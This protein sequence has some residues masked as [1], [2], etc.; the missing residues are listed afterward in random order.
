MKKASRNIFFFLILFIFFLGLIPRFFVLDKVQRAITHEI[1]KRM[2]SAVAIQKMHWSWLPLPHLTLVNMDISNADF[3]ISLPQVN[4]YP[5]WRIILGETHT[6]QKIVLN[7]P[8]INIAKTVF[9]TEAS[10]DPDMPEVTVIVKNGAIEVETAEKYTD[11]LRTDSLL[12]SNI[13][14]RFKLMPQWADF[15]LQAASPF[16]SSMSL[17]GRFNIPDKSY[18]FSLDSQN[19]KLH[20]SVKAFL[21]GRLVPVESTASLNAIVSGKG[22]QHFE[23][24]L[25]GTLPSFTI[26][27]EDRETLL[28]GGFA[29]MKLLKSGPLLRLDIFDLEIKDP[30]ANLS[31]HIEHKLSSA[32]DAEPSQTSDAIWTI[33]MTG[34]DM[35]LAALRQKVLTLWGHNMVAKTVSD[36]VLDGKALSASFRFAGRTADFTD[37]NAMIIEADLL[38]AAVH[39]P[40]VDLDLTQASGPIQIKDSILTGHDLSAKL[41]NSSGRNGEIFLDLSTHGKKFK[42]AVDIEA[43]VAEL[44]PVLARL[45]HHDPFQRELSKFSEVSGNASGTL[46]LGDKLDA[47]VTRVDVKDAQ[48]TARYEPIPKK[49]A[50][51]S[52]S[53]HVDPEK[54]SWQ[55]V[56]GR[57]GKQEITA[58]SGNVSW[59]GGEALLNIAEIKALLQGS[60]LHAMLKQTGI[61]PPKIDS[62]LSSLNGTIKVTHGT[63]TGPAR[64]PESWKYDLALTA[65]DLTVASPLL[66]EI[67]ATRKISAELNNETARIKKAEIQFL[68]QTFSLAGL[69]KHHLLENW[70]GMIEFNGPVLAKLA[71]WISSKGWFPEKLRPQIPCTMEDM[72]VNW[73]DETLSVS[74]IIL[75]GLSG[76]RLPMARIDYENTPEHLRINELTFYAAGEQGH[77]ALDFWRLSPNSLMLSWTGHVNADTI[78][79][80]FWH[81]SFSSGTFSGDFKISYFADK[82]EATLFEGI[83]TAEDLHLK[84]NS[85]GEPIVITSM[86]TSGIGKQ[87]RIPGMAIGIGSE[88]VN[89]SG[90]L[91]VEKDG[92]HLDISLG[93]SILSKK[94]LVG[95][96]EAMQATR[97]NFFNSPTESGID[98]ARGWDMTG[99]IGFDF[100]SFILRRE[101]PMPYE[102]ALPVTYTFYD[103]H[104]DLQLAPD[105]LSRTEIFSSKLCGLDFKGFWFS[106][107]GLGQKFELDTGPNETLHLENVLPCLG[108]QQDIIEGE[109]SLQANLLKESNAWYGGNIHIRSS[110]GRIQVVNITDLF[111]QQVEYAG[112]KGFPFNQMD[113]DT[114][115][116]GNNLIFDRAIIRGEGLNLFARGEVHLDDYDADLTLLIA[117]F[118]TFDSMVSKVPIIGQPIMGQN[119]SMVSIPVA[120]KGPIADPAITPL[121]PEA[122][123]DA[124]LDL[125]KDTFMLPYNIFKPQEKSADQNDE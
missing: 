30:Q 105:K 11:V 19:I 111:E 23:A 80:L 93:S 73:Q 106:D 96:S 102:A 32:R 72:K 83:L 54:V 39:V 109:F 24:D 49:F 60:A 63:I 31:G 6:L 77:L 116:E 114:H 17:Q 55:K 8:K 51:D 74:G 101:R 18:Q 27:F 4:I 70:H 37:M 44:P 112:K 75:H 43:D 120:I 62:V 123:G 15:Y 7:K 122:I 88:R 89:G 113:I 90:Q 79:A 1:S 85:G 69:L 5:S 64:Q 59:H 67:V 65:T 92:L 35:D 87:L 47:I 45:V 94:S 104:G 103:V 78:D 58:T 46:H 20:E 97:D 81:S 10:S 52:G 9:L 57:I 14:G 71:S 50:I 66:P 21:Q 119:G 125:V 100:D 26:R 115:I 98:I 68:E 99:R 108:V 34:S 2:D 36:I 95:L 16:S 38:N 41:G 29:D 61:I 28:A 56:K 48:L 53:L 12:F 118:K 82:P 107:A 84:T 13:N 110:Q 91:A 40:Q 25:R 76:G 3:R 117:P 33:D 42:L 22:L 121:H 124:F 86:T